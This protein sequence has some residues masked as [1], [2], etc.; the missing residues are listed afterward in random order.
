[1]KNTLVGLLALG[2]AFM[3]G[4]DMAARNTPL[5]LIGLGMFLAG[6][7]LGTIVKEK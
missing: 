5:W 7:T 3:S 4:Y 2:L 1:M 6:V